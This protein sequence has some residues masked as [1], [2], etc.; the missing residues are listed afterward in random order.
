MYPEGYMTSLALSRAFT[1]FKRS[2]QGA[3][4]KEEQALAIQQ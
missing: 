3:K 2:G 4:Q 1:N